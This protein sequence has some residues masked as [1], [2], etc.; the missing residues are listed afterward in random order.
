ALQSEHQTIIKERRM[1]KAVA[2]SDQSVSDA[3]EIE[4]AIPVGIIAG[5]PGDFEA[6]HDANVAER[7]FRGHAGEPGALGESGA[8]HTEI[9]VDDD[10][11]FLGPTEFTR[12]PLPLQKKN[13]S[14][15]FGVVSNADNT[16]SGR[17]V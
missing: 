11:L 13:F 15:T 4:Q 16:N 8:G 9:F 3:A 5:H 14:L 2:V 17:I 1:V 12:F 10:H 6:E 7:H